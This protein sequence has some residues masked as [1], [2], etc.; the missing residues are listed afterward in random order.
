MTV[1]LT[2]TAYDKDKKEISPKKT[3]SVMIN[4]ETVSVTQNLNYAESK[5][6]EENL[7]FLGFGKYKVS[8]PKIILDT[9]GVIPR[10]EWPNDRTDVLGMINDL[11]DVVGGYVSSE[12]ETPTVRVQW[13]S[14]IYWCKMLSISYQLQLF[15]SEGEPVRAEISLDFECH[16]TEREI[17]A[18]KN[19]NSPDLTHL[20]EVKA[21]DTLPLMCERVYHDSSLYLQV[22]RFN[23]LTNFRRLKVGSRLVFPPIVD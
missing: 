21:G 15:N 18:T 6:N 14:S 8:F 11:K 7:K 4:P 9:T 22:A 17:Q 5:N 20:V 1:K 3:F 2:L 10:S 19:K 16:E 23:H 13:G 12:H